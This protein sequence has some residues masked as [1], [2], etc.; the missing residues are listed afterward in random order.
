MCEPLRIFLSLRESRRLWLSKMSNKSF[1]LLRSSDLWSL[2]VRDLAKIQDFYFGA[3]IPD[4]G[5]SLFFDFEIATRFWTVFGAQDEL[6][7]HWIRFGRVT[8]SDGF[9]LVLPCVGAET[10]CDPRQ[11]WFM[12]RFCSAFMNQTHGIDQ[13]KESGIWSAVCRLGSDFDHDCG[14]C[15]LSS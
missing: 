8:P 13:K 2:K 12:F 7:A 6:E 10:G 11:D 1:Y 5:V 9:I 3:P 15:T 4:L 14:S